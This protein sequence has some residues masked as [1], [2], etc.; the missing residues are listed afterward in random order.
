MT[1]NLVLFLLSMLAISLA[2]EP[3]A[4]KLRLPFSSLLVIVGFVGSE[5][6]VAA[7]LDTGVRWNLFHDLI[8]FVLLP[9]LIFEA[10]LH[11]RMRELLRMIL[12]ILLLA[13]PFLLLSTVVCAFLLYWSI[14]NDAGFPW[15]A[16]LFTG[17]I[18]SATD[19]MAVLVIMKKVGAPRQL[20]MLMDGESLF[21][22]ATAIVV[23]M[24]VISLATSS[25]T[26]FAIGAAVIE[27]LKIFF[28]GAFLGVL[29]G[30]AALAL[31]RIASGGLQQTAVS[32]ITAYGAY[33]ASEALL[34]VSG[35]LA[36]MFAG[37]TISWKL[38]KGIGDSK[39]IFVF[40]EQLSYLANSLV[41]LLL[42]VTITFTMI[43]LQ[44]LAMLYGIG[45]ALISRW[46]AVYLALPVSN[47]V[48]GTNTTPGVYRPVMFWGGLRGAVTIALALAIPLQA[49]WW[50]TAQS[51]AYGVVL[52]SLF[53]QAPTMPAL[54]RKV[55]LAGNR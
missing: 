11:I 37:L 47:L 6:V 49:D 17:A 14:G 31:M 34:D 25:G 41:F 32:L 24:L 2:V 8:L 35:V 50:F 9:I 54:L 29:A 27:F 51:I 26:D 21:N 52:F 46:L 12:P 40:W 39:R 22:D 28:G 13:V 4:D 20:E 19:P 55:D 48:S 30:L 53:V 5:I 23:A 33:V 18:L 36:A 1:I 15:L 43:K 42:G 44:W 16:A 10:S 7:G 38:H 3:L 45:A